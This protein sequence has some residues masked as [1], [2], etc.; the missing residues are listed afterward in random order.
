MG[1]M[2]PSP[3]ARSR[4]IAL[5][6]GLAY[7]VL[8]WDGGGDHT[9]V[10]VHGFL[11]LAWAWDAVATRLAAGG[12]HVIAPDLRGHGDSD[13]VGAGGYYHFFDYVADLDEVVAR[14]GRTQ[15][16][17]VGHS[18]GGSVGA[19]W[20]GTRPER[21]AR[22]ALLEGIGPPETTASVPQRTATWIDA[23]RRARSEPPKVLASVEEA[24][25]RIRK[26]D[27]LLDPAD[28]LRLAEHGTRAVPDGVI[29]KHDPLHLTAGPYLYR[30]DV[31][32][33][34]WRRVTA[35]VL[36]LE[37]ARSM[38]RLPDPEV[39][40]RLAVFPSARRVTI[41]DAGHALQ[42]HQPERVAAA[43]LEHL[44]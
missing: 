2:S 23:W 25:A 36:Y 5:T 10:L 12:Y 31:A 14:C 24:A 40:R 21:V 4:H 28:A 19:Y 41:A 22:L 43:L 17:V 7:H 35:P 44:A 13:R 16:S 32:E 29:W 6:N 34:F 15:V 27:A 39:D 30:V 20:A 33:S 9:V 38:L 26:Y 42:R 3:A 11:D 37:G 1:T 8:E 18:M